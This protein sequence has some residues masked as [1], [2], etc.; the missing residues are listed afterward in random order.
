MTLRHLGWI[1]FVASLVGC[2]HQEIDLAGRKCPCADDYECDAV[3]A[4]CVPPGTVAGAHCAKG[5]DACV[6]KVTFSDFKPAWVTPNSIRWTWQPDGQADVWAPSFQSYRL[7]LEA[8]DQKLTYDSSTNPELGLA[9]LPNSSPDPTSA[10]TSDGLTP[11]TTYT[12]TLIVR[13]TSGCEFSSSRLAPA[14]PIALSSSPLEIFGESPFTGSILD[15]AIVASGC[16][17][18]AQCL[19]TDDCVLAPNK[20]LCTK[21]LRVYAIDVGPGA[22]SA[23]GFSQAYLEFFARTDTPAPSYYSTVFLELGGAFY[24]FEGLTFPSSAEYRRVQVPLHALASSTQSL[25]FAT[26]QASHIVQFNF[27]THVAEG[28]H[29]WLDEVYVRW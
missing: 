19:M 23:G 24:R 17:F 15:G 28:A 1:A 8:G 22:M 18:G 14:T 13:D 27:G 25:D 16:Q 7:E 9:V 2:G 10:T 21:N 5:P 29:T 20:T 12:G 6:A 26:L 4:V 11:G 3:C